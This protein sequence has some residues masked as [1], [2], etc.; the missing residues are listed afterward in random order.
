MRCSIMLVES[1][2]WN[3]TVRPISQL[4]QLITY[5]MPFSD[6]FDPDFLSS[7]PSGLKHLVLVIT[8][9]IYNRNSGTHL[10]ISTEQEEKPRIHIYSSIIGWSSH[11]NNATALAHHLVNTV[12]RIYRDNWFRILTRPCIGQL[13]RFTEVAIIRRPNNNNGSN[14][15]MDRS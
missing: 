5:W 12:Q 3:G 6:E 14:T 9:L 1:Q 4:L 2:G 8:L 11:Q 13:M 15:I 10:S 7:W